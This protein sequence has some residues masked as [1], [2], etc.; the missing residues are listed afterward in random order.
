MSPTLT[1]SSIGKDYPTRNG[2]LTVLDDITLTLQ[3]GEAA[4]VMGTSGCG[5]STML[6]IF[7]TLERPSR[8]RL[9]VGGRDPFALSSDALAA[10]RNDQVGFI[11]QDHHL[12]GHC[13]L[14][15]NVLIPRL[16]TGPVGKT[17]VERAMALL[18]RVGLADRLDHLPAELSGGERQRT[19]VARA[20]INRP[21]LILADEP[22]GNLDRHSAQA[23]ADLL[24]ELHRE[25]STI[26]VLVTHNSAL[27]ERLPR[28]FEL[29]D[30]RLNELAAG[31]V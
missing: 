11:F 29:I 22:T 28:R 6:S 19:A 14:L 4:A 9:T 31:A 24:L 2:P 16:P 5:K 3:A 27:A 7:G 26:L 17:A 25:E 8:G 21:T 10:F 12:L 15:E 30:G 13:T 23:V 1:A 18:D 20:L